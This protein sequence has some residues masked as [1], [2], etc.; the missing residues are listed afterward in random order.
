MNVNDPN[1]KEEQ[2]GNAIGT[3]FLVFGVMGGTV[4]ALLLI[5]ILAKALGG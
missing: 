1:N 3:V 2:V 4:L 5:L